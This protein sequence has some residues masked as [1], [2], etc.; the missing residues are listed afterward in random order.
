MTNKRTEKAKEP[1]N[2]PSTGQGGVVP[3]IP[4]LNFGPKKPSIF[5]G[6]KG[7]SPKGNPRGK[8]NQATFHTQHK[9]G[10]SGG[11]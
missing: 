7:F 5:S 1:S 3:K 11:K 6:N 8:F 10:P 9:G 4:T 2:Q